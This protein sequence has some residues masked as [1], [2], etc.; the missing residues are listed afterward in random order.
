[1]QDRAILGPEAG[2]AVPAED[3][4]VDLYVAT[5]WLHVDQEQVAPCLGLPKE[6]VRLHLAGVGGA[7][8]ARE[9]VSMHIHACM[10]ALRTGRPVK[11]VYGREESFFGHVHRHPS[12]IWMRT[13]ATRAD[14]DQTTVARGA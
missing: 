13:G 12:R 9:D 14:V 10:L 2:M 5:Q 11:I 3:G 1:M 4:G 7:F 8:G 6:K